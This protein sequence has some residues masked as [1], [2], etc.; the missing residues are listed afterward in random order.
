MSI[1]K[2]EATTAE[3]A[4]Q[5]FCSSMACGP[6]DCHYPCIFIQRAF[7]GETLSER[8]AEPGKTAREIAIKVIGYNHDSAE[9]KMIPFTEAVSIIQSA[10]DDAKREECEGMNESHRL[11]SKATAERD[12]YLEALRYYASASKDGVV[13][14]KVMRIIE[15]D[16][17]IARAAIQGGKDNHNER[18]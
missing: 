2:M 7:G 12:R 18:G 1:D 6:S 14:C 5:I 3:K 16:G 9:C 10:L 13:R 4:G 17:S 11:L 15:E 8:K